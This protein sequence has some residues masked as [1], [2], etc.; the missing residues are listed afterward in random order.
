M[1]GCVLLV[2]VAYGATVEVAHSHG[3][4]APGGERVTAMSGAG[5]ADSHKTG[6]HRGECTTCQFQQQLFNGL[7]QAPLVAL[8]PE[9][10]A[11]LVATLAVLHPSPS[12]TPTS[13]RAPPT[14]L[15]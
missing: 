13:D 2:L 5:G 7:V 10:H 12:T 3:S 4:V 15:V 9:T 14:E 8:N 6:S 1:L 11:A